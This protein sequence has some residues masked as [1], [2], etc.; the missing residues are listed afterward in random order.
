MSASS[1]GPRQ[2]AG[3]PRASDPAGGAA[4]ILLPGPRGARN[5]GTAR[6]E[7]R[8]RATPGAAAGSAHRGLARW[9]VL[10]R[11]AT[12]REVADAGVTTGHGDR[13][14]GSTRLS[15]IELGTSSSRCRALP[16]QARER[17]LVHGSFQARVTECTPGRRPHSRVFRPPTPMTS[18]CRCDSHCDAGRLER[19]STCLLAL[20]GDDHSGATPESACLRHIVDR[21]DGP[22]KLFA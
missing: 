3:R 15:S 12:D 17:T 8:S 1:R 9:P 10:R 4:P 11:S 22:Y 13:P 20:T 19:V 18:S 14:S 7:A 21:E 6:S 2:T 16:G 5:L